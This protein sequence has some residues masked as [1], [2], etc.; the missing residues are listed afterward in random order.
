MQQPECQKQVISCITYRLCTALE[1]GVEIGV[2]NWFEQTTEH[3]ENVD[4]FPS[5]FTTHTECWRNSRIRK[6][7]IE[8]KR[9]KPVE[10]VLIWGSEMEKMF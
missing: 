4:P 3:S 8:F 5:P 9:R 10:P 7:I 6:L 2:E 1:I